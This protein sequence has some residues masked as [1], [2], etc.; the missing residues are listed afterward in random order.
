MEY[1]KAIAKGKLYS[2]EFLYFNTERSENDQMLHFEILDKNK[3][4]AKP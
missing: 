2:Y 3:K 4:Q 1:G